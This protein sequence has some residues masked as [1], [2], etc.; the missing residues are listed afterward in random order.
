MKLKTRIHVFTTL[1]MFF[2]LAGLSIGIYFLFEKM[3]YE[4][5][6]GQ[7]MARGE[8]LTAELNE[9]APADANMV[10]R[11][12]MPPDG[13]LHIIGADGRVIRKVESDSRLRNF[14]AEPSGNGPYTI[15]D[16]KG[17]PAVTVAMPFISTG[18][19]VAE[20]RITQLAD[21]IAHE[22]SLL[23]LILTG[24]TAAAMIPVIVSSVALGRIVTR[25]INVLTG[26]MRENREK[27][28]YEKIDEGHGR[29]ELHEM[30]LAYNDMMDQLGRNYEKQERFV[31]DA[32]HE[33]KTPITVI[34]SYARLLKR[35]GFDD[36]NV[37]DEAVGAILSQAVRMKEL[38]AQLL[39][40][41]RSD[42]A[43]AYS[44]KQADIRDIAEETVRPMR[45]AYGR[46]F[47]VEGPEKLLADTDPDKL[48]QLLF[49]LLD[50]ARKYSD[51]DVRLAL[52]KTDGRVEL[53]VADHGPGIPEA[54]LP[55]L[56]DRFYRVNSDRNRKTGGTGLGLALAKEI[57][58]GLGAE[59]TVES[60][61]GVGTVFRICFAS[62]RPKRHHAVTE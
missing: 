56:F 17:V 48:R 18:G 20:L 59:L 3:T 42:R 57:A 32:S 38:T 39:D 54:D 19:E 41:A 49:I 9:I 40:L 24:L 26:T 30:A 60:V 1:L 43:A 27:G 53:S 62:S 12:Y 44:F 22:L 46:E 11:A 50:N 16:I 33:L 28:A 36:R 8:K 52:E 61:I 6:A 5:Q 15:T 55:H 47:V 14:T 25:P 37:A 31:S 51:G 34:E 13:A 35:R 7:L 10:I 2:I 58:D 21:D 45:Q 29:D 23:R 4:R